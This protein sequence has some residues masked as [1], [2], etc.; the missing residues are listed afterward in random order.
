MALRLKTLGPADSK[1]KATC[2]REICEICVRQKNRFVLIRVNL[3]AN[4]LVRTTPY[5]IIAILFPQWFLFPIVGE[6]HGDLVNAQRPVRVFTHSIKSK[7]SA[8]VRWSMGSVAESVAT[9]VL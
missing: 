2:L 9:K 5:Y 8:L 7:S 1:S 3:W 4:N 6:A